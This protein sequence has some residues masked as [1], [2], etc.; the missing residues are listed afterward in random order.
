MGKTRNKKG[1]ET[2]RKF[3]EI[4]VRRMRLDELEPAPRNP[5]YIT[6]AARAGL[7]ASVQRVGWVEPV[8]WNRR[9]NRIVGG[10]QRVKA[11]WTSNVE[12]CD[13]VE[14]D[15]D[16]GEEMALNLALNSPH[17]AGEWTDDIVPLL[18]EL[19]TKFPQ[20][21]EIRLDVLLKDL[22]GTKPELGQELDEGVADGIEVCVCK[23]C[24]NEH[25]RLKQPEG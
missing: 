18:E 8:V 23:T 20:F 7:T 1:K 2:P 4:K 24:G 19:E 13:V 9:S 22:G 6:D 16:E 17:I 15:L 3:G 21:A 14:V 11:L 12:E 5:R 25:H 10:H